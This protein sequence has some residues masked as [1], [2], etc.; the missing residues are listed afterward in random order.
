MF[1]NRSLS[2]EQIL[3]LYNGRF[4]L[5]VSQEITRG[6]LWNVSITPN[7]GYEEGSVLT[8]NTITIINS[9]PTFNQSLVAKNINS[10]QTF[11]YD[12]NCS[13]TDLSDPI[14]YYDNASLFDINSATGL[15]TDYT[16]QD[17]AG[18]YTINISCSDGLVNTS[19]TFIYTI[20]DVSKPT[21]KD[22]VWPIFT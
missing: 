16:I 7:D 6:D 4:D 22:S 14:I 11:T 3:A 1:F 10:G 5:I 20:N 2:A 12:I 8:S 9:A 15:I 17:N 19:E 13:D 18:S 21:F